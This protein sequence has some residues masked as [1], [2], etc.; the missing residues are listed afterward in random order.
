[1]CCNGRWSAR[2]SIVAIALIAASVLMTSGCGVDQPGPA[3]TPLAPPA[4]APRPVPSPSPPPLYVPLPPGAPRSTTTLTFTSDP[5]DY[6]GGGLSR[7]YYLGDGQWNARYD[8]NNSG[9]HVN[10]SLNPTNF[11]EGWWWHVD[12]AS[13]KGQPLA[14]GAYELARRYPFQPDG[15][16]GLDFSGTGRGCNM[17]TGRFSISELHIAPGNFVDRLTATFEQHCEGA[18]PAL[19]GS[20]VIA[21]DPWR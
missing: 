9:G 15:Q 12:L 1:M 20:V 11:S 10:V 19:R 3:P 8:T 7:T 18:S 16:P 21:A 5:G 6:I 17:L 4:P 14:I 2:A 13:P